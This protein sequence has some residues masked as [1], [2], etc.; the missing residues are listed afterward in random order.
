MGKFDLII[1]GLGIL[2]LGGGFLL[3][4]PQGK[5]LLSQFTDAF[6]D[7][8]E[9]VEYEDPYKYLTKDTLEEFTP[10]SKAWKQIQ[11]RIWEEKDEKKGKKNKKVQ[12][13]YIEA[14]MAD[15]YY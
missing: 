9:A 2:G 6:A 11:K 15:A 4:T 10:G 14:Y 13:E 12:N 1:I 8:E 7:T 5:R 3:F